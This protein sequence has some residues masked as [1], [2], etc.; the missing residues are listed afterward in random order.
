MFL[1]QYEHAIDDKGRMTIPAKFRT[2]LE[3]GAYLTQGFDQNLMVLTTSSF[4]QLYQRIN[5]MSITDPSA[6]QLRRLFFSSAT[7]VEFDRAGRI[8]IPQFLRDFAHLQTSALV[9]GSGEFVEIW[10][11]EAWAHQTS[12]LQ[13]AELNAQRFASL[14]L[15]GGQL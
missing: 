11:P 4:E 7:Q 8:L 1:G 14:D 9:V 10:T 15:S 13:N 2:L 12:D 6:R 3:E 5:Q